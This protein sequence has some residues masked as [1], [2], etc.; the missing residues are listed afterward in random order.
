MGRVICFSPDLRMTLLL[1][2][3]T[4]DRMS[5]GL[6]DSNL[7]IS[8]HSPIAIGIVPKISYLLRRAVEIP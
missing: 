8:W 2:K 5:R 1:L 4:F 6:N 3:E 7:D